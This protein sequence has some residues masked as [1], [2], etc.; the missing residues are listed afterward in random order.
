MEVWFCLLDLRTF[1]IIFIFW[2]AKSCSFQHKYICYGCWNLCGWESLY[3]HRASYIDSG[4]LANIPSWRPQENCWS[5]L[6]W[7]RDRFSLNGALYAVECPCIVLIWLPWMT[8]FLES[9]L[10]LLY[11]RCYG[12]ELS[13]LST[14]ICFYLGSLLLFWMTSASRSL[15]AAQSWFWMNLVKSFLKNLTTLLYSSCLM[16]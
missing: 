16:T 12:P 9:M 15:G 7:C 10:V 8:Y 13:Q 6:T 14:E 2:L 11:H 3:L 4:Y 1:C 5:K